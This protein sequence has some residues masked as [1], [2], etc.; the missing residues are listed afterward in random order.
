MKAAGAETSATAPLVSARMFDFGETAVMTAL[1]K[2]GDGYSQCSRIWVHRDDH[3]QM[4][5]SYQTKVE[6]AAPEGNKST[7]SVR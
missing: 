1:H 2:T 6:K 7:S 5:I 4:S 3:W